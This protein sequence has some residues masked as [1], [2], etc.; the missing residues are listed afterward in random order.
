MKI[1][2]QENQH[3]F[4]KDHPPVMKQLVL[5]STGEEKVLIAGNVIT[6][7]TNTSTQVVTTGEFAMPGEGE[8]GGVIGILAEDVTIPATGDAYANIYVHAEVIASEL[9][10]PDGVSVEDKKA[11]L[12][13]LRKI[14]IFAGE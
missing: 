10:W 7:N 5:T 8:T 12:E 14:G 2:A 6:R 13:E 1:I 9:V 3:N 11:A 4:L